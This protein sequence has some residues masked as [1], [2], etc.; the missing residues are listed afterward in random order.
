MVLTWTSSYAYASQTLDALGRLPP[1]IFLSSIQATQRM[2]APS[3]ARNSSM[4]P[5]EF[6]SV[7][8]MGDK[9]PS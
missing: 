5:M 6:F 3:L 4:P 7:R 8:T 1:A 9:V 2:E